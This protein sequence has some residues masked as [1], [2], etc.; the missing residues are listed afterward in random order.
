MHVNSCAW[1]SVNEHEPFVHEVSFQLKVFVECREALGLI[2][3]Q[4]Y[5][6]CL[7]TCISHVY[8]S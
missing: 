6:T 7:Y 1:V 4:V 3:V 5:V 8:A 2:E